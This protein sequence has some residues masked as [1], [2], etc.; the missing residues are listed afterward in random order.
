M[1]E[2]RLSYR[3]PASSVPAHACLRE[4]HA[5]FNAAPAA[6]RWAGFIIQATEASEDPRT[7]EEWAKAVSVSRSVLIESC[8]RL[9][10][11]PRDARDLARVLRL[12]RRVDD[13]WEPDL[14]LAVADRRTLRV[15]LDRAGVDVAASAA[16]P[17]LEQF[18]DG[19]RFVPQSNPGLAALRR[20]LGAAAHLTH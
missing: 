3:E 8:A 17:T 1:L 16:R 5:P 7:L 13:P 4:R 14:A 11:S 10:V 20:L 15:L 9:G 6:Y 2:D 19:Q 18:L 12:V